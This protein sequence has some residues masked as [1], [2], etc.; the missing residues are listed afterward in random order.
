[1]VN[2]NSYYLSEYVGFKKSVSWSLFF[3]QKKKT[4]FNQSYEMEKRAGPVSP[5]HLLC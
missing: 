5:D 3:F 2:M 4:W 1:M